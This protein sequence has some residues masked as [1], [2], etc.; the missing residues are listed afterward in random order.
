HRGF[1]TESSPAARKTG[2]A[3]RLPFASQCSSTNSVTNTENSKYHLPQLPL[4]T[5]AQDVF[6]K[7]ASKQPYSKGNPHPAGRK[8]HGGQDVANRVL[9][10]CASCEAHEM[11]QQ[12]DLGSDVYMVNEGIVRFCKNCGSSTF[13]KRA[14]DAAEGEAAPPQIE[15]EPDFPEPEEPESIDSP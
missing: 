9:L 12:S 14:D 10:H 4:G 6:R 2:A 15:E 11:V 3:V 7:I 1:Y 5:G 13:W 8:R